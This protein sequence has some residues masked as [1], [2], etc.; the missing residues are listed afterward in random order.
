MTYK[1]PTPQVGWRVRPWTA[2]IGVA[3]STF[4]QLDPPPESILLGTSRIILESPADYIA[5]V[6]ALTAQQDAA[7]SEAKAKAKRLAEQRVSNRKARARDPRTQQPALP[8]PRGRPRK[9]PRIA[10]PDIPK[11]A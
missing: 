10:S 5:R 7:E 8:R 2:A 4:Y 9:Q 6:A 3:G 11:T 1:T